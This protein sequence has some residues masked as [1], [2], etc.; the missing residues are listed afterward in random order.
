MLI[1]QNIFSFFYI[2][3]CLYKHR[4]R[5]D[6]KKRT[7]VFILATK[8]RSEGV[9]H[10][11]EDATAMQLRGSARLH[12][13]KTQRNRRPSV[14]RPEAGGSSHA[15]AIFPS[16]FTARVSTLV[17]FLFSCSRGET[18]AGLSLNR[19]LIARKSYKTPRRCDEQL[20]IY[21]QLYTL[22]CFHVARFS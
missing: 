18:M 17:L 15:P 6:K 12:R 5:K 10:R 9:V 8:S 1:F 11:H 2:I 7:N 4:Y 14:Q 16:R 13:V 20:K 3:V 19:D 21:V 22:P